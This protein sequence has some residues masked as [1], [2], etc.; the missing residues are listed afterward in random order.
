MQKFPSCKMGLLILPFTSLRWKIFRAVSLQKQC[1][2]TVILVAV[3]R[4]ILVHI[5]HTV[6]F[7]QNC[8]LQKPRF[9][10]HFSCLPV[11]RIHNTGMLWYH[12]KINI[13]LKFCFSNTNYSLIVGDEQSSVIHSNYMSC[14]P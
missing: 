13:I 11:N 4:N 8:I 12:D 7:V 6:T 3:G 10:H 9:C 2:Q 1:V 14:H 5:N